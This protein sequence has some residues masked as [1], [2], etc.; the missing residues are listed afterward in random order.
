[1][2]SERAAEADAE[3]DKSFAAL[4][5]RATV[6]TPDGRRLLG[7]VS[8]AIRKGEHWAV[9]GPN[10]AGKTTLLRLLGAERHPSSGSV[11]VLGSRLGTSDLRLVR[12]RV[13]V[14]SHAVADRLPPS[15]SAVDV[16]LTGGRNVLAAVVG[17]QR[18]RR[19]GP[20][21]ADTLRPRLW[22]TGGPRLRLVLAG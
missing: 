1:M 12:S 7:P 10:G 2:A 17:P 14:V 21:A 4:L 19:P 15:A 3:S 11:T 9:L 8:V 6:V 5:D 16:V 13:G 22:A 20:R 18:G